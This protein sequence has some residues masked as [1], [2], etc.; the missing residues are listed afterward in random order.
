M[1]L[2]NLRLKYDSYNENNFNS[3]QG[4]RSRKNSLRVKWSNEI[5]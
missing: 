4:K 5:V 3:L 2:Q 1:A